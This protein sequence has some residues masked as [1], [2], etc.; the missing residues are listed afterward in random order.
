MSG[1]GFVV[2]LT[3]LPGSGKTTLAS[4]VS[5]ELSRRGRACCLLD[6]DALRADLSSDLDFSPA[7]RAENVRRAAAVAG[8]VVGSGMA[9]VVAMISPFEA[10]RKRARERFRRGAFLEVHLDC[11]VEVCR[12]R[13]PKGLYARSKSGSVAGLTGVDQP[14][15]T[16]SSPELRL[17]T[18]RESADA[19]A[20]RIM[21][22][23]Q[24]AGLL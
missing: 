7:G 10:D 17:R 6:G 5:E 15:E 13:D 18:D 12:A 9:A 3:G 4:A 1:Q 21:Q 14:Y 23:L 24:E 19:C 2:W 16:P 11:P 20:E 8:L 22:H